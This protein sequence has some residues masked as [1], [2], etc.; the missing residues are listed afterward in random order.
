VSFRMA[1]VIAGS[2]ASLNYE[3]GKATEPSVTNSPVVHER[4]L[5]NQEFNSLEDR[6]VIVVKIG[7]NS[8]TPPI[9]R[10]RPNNFPIARPRPIYVNPYRTAPKLVNRR[11]GAERMNTAGANSGGG[12]GNASL[13]ITVQFQ[14][15]QK[16]NNHKN[17]KLLIM[18]IV[19]LVK[20]K[21]NQKNNQMKKNMNWTK[22]SKL[23]K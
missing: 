7:G 12:G 11:L 23:K 17:Q 16:K 9:P 3:S 14:K 2:L 15:F 10:S 21:S 6:K 22:T 8:N 13:M 5:L 1:I 20:K 4:L 19:S 18:I